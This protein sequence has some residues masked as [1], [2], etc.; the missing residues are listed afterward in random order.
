MSPGRK[1]Y[2]GKEGVGGMKIEQFVMA[3][4][5]EQDRLRAMLP[6]GF[7]SLRPV[8]RINGEIRYG[9]QGR[10]LY[11]EFNTPVAGFGK[12]GWLNIAHWNTPETDI[13]LEC[14]EEG[15]AFSAPFL[16][17]TFTGTG[18]AGGCPAEK[19]NDG[20]FFLGEE[21]CFRPAEQID[22]NKE[23]CEC[24]FCWRFSG[25]DARGAGEGGGSV[26]AIPTLPQKEYE[27]RP[28]SA[29]EAAAIPCW[30]VLGSYRVTF[31]RC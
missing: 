7:E 11:L 19:D 15:I 12:R 29:P 28:L 21:C 14:G 6:E 2:S 5:V 23:Y 4:R 22:Q 24:T 20:C 1:R 13:S 17:I 3:Y 8:L 16:E 27:R 31:N 10:Q 26:A 25:E 18:N 30:Q 9:A